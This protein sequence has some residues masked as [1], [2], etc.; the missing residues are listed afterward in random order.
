MPRRA[1]LL[2]R[3]VQSVLDQTCYGFELIDV[4]YG[5]TDATHEVVCKSQDC[6]IRHI[7]HKENRSSSAWRLDYEY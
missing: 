7:R 4:G 2:G 6:R 5:F 1:D 3:A